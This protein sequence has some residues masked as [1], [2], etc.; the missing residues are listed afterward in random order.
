MPKHIRDMT[1]QEVGEHLFPHRKRTRETL[2]RAKS[3]AALA[4]QLMAEYRT[5]AARLEHAA[6]AQSWRGNQP[7]E[8]WVQ[9]T[10]NLASARRELEV[11]FKSLIVNQQEPKK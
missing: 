7:T 4:D 10:K 2:A 6:V 1:S 9:I 5:K 11:L 8:E 3:N